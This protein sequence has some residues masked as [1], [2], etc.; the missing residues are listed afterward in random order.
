MKKIVFVAMAV[1]MVAGLAQ[2]KEK[3][4]ENMQN[5]VSIDCTSATPIACGDVVSSTNVG[6]TMNFDAYG[7]GYSNQTGPEVFFTFTLAE[8][9]E[10]TAGLTDMSADLDI[11]L[12]V[13]GDDVDCLA[14]ANASFTI[15]LL[16][17]DYYIAVDGYNGAESDFTLTLTCEPILPPQPGETC[18]TALEL[19]DD[20]L[21]NTCPGAE[22]W[23][24]FTAPFDGMIIIDTCIPDQTVD[25]YVRVYD[26]CGG[27]QLAYND[28][29]S[30]EFY[31]YA[32]YL[33]APVTGGQT[34]YIMFDDNWSSDPF[35]FNFYVSDGTVATD[36]ASFDSIKAMY[37]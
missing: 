24:S 5:R 15:E 32:S 34:Y 36:G 30:C 6:G 16:A 19:I 3:S 20:D 13:C 2:A 7:C 27:E 28:D 18:E 17:G 10:V 25:T 4:P 26:A 8:D 21:T 9:A 31:N 23:Y 35:D 22:F 12:G 1:L 33:E 37:R 14:G 11:F 29:A